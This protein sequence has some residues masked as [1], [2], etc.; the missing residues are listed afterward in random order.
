MYVWSMQRVVPFVW[1]V[2]HMYIAQM[3]FYSYIHVSIV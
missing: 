2:T 3:Y 1:M